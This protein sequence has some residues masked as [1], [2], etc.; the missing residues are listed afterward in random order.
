MLWATISSI[1]DEEISRRKLSIMEY[2]NEDPLIKQ[3]RE[4]YQQ[5]KFS[6]HKYDLRITNGS[7]TVVNKVKKDYNLNKVDVEE[8]DDGFDEEGGGAKKRRRRS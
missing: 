4:T 8:G 5:L 2:E 7:Y 1:L 3:V 6:R